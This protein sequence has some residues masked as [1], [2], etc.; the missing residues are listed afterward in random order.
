MPKLRT[1][2][3]LIPYPDYTYMGWRLEAG[4][5]LNSCHLVV[6]EPIAVHAI[7]L[8]QY[9][10]VRAVLKEIKLLLLRITNF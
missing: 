6:R 9:D 4:E 10:K 8:Q 5:T 2:R 1:Y 3:V 7:G